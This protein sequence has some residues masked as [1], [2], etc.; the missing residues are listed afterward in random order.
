MMVIS[1]LQMMKQG[2]EGLNYPQSHREQGDFKLR[3]SGSRIWA[4]L[5]PELQLPVKQQGHPTLPLPSDSTPTC[6]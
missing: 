2:T 6:P 4:L 5:N 1:T 3:H